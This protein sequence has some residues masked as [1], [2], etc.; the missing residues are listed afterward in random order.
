MKR[1]LII[2]LTLTLTVSLT[3]CGLFK[4][5]AK[6]AAYDNLHTK[7]DKQGQFKKSKTKSHL[8]PKDMKKTKRKKKMVKKKKI[9]RRKMSKRSVD[10][11]KKYRNKRRR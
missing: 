2:V 6:C 1:L 11:R 10:K 5:P 9:D 7:T 4:R 8:F 3:S